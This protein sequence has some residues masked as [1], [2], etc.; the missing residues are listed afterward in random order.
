VA[1]LVDTNILVY[2]FDGRFP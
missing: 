2:R 1:A